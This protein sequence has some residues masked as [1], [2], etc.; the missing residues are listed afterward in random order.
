MSRIRSA[1]VHLLLRTLDPA[2]RDVVEGDLREL[3]VSQTRAV[4]ELL[5]LVAR[6]QIAAWLG[7]R[8]WAG[9]VFIVVPLGVVLSLVSRQWAINTAMYAWFYVDNWTPG[10]F[11]SPGARGDLLNAATEVLARGIAL[12]LWAWTVG[13]A[14]AS[15]SSRTAWV[16]YAALGLV[17]F[18]ASVG[19]T[20]AGVRNPANVVVFSQALYR[21]GFP[22]LSRFLFVMLPALHG[23][24][25]AL[26]EP[27]LTWVHAAA[28]AVSVTLVTA[29]GWWSLSADGPAIVA[30]FRLRGAWPLKLLPFAMT[31]PAAYVVSNVSWRSWK[32]RAR[33]F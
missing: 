29:A 16:T 30:I 28:L 9:V 1:V 13:F 3:R 25:K 32:R 18:G 12:S 26:R 4:R 31:L 6:R 23:I 20:T 24:R 33:S 2:E 19:S 27:T 11:G 10:Y 15:V 5:G 17:V 14:I 21:V 22:F 7:W 8:P